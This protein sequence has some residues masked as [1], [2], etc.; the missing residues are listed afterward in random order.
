VYVHTVHPWRG[1][2]KSI[3]K[4]KAREHCVI[5]QKLWQKWTLQLGSAAALHWN[6]YRIGVGLLSVVTVLVECTLYTH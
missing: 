5:K 2:W 3:K 4:I 6:R 1:G